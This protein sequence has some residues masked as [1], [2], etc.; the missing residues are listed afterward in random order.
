MLG[1]PQEVIDEER[2]WN[3]KQC[4]HEFH[5][6]YYGTEWD[7]ECKK[8]DKNVFDI[9]EKEDALKIIDSLTKR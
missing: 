6:V 5:S 1:T 7:V 2:Y 3:N 9:Y 4:L 8:C